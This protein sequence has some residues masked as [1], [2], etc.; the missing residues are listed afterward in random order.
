M[1]TFSTLVTINASMLGCPATNCLVTLKSSRGKYVQASL[2]GAISATSRNINEKA[3][4]YIYFIGNNVINLRNKESGKYLTARATGILRHDRERDPNS[5][6]KFTLEYYG[7]N[8]YALKTFHGKYMTQAIFL[9]GNAARVG[10]TELFQI[11][12][13]L[14]SVV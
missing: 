1:I 9:L 6:E 8:N 3:K 4:W 13:F 7:D 10:Q 12:A 5:W 11:H 2:A 14:A